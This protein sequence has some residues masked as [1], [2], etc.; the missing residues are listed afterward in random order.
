MVKPSWTFYY[1]LAVKYFDY[2]GDLNMDSNFKTIDGINYN[3]E[4]ID[5]GVWVT[6]Q[7]KLCQKGSIYKRRLE[8]LKKLNV[9][10]EVDLMDEKYLE[11]AQNYF[12]HYHNLNLPRAFKTKNGYDYDEDGVDLSEWLTSQIKASK[13]G[14]LNPTLK[15]ALKAIGMSFDFNELKWNKQYELAKTYYEFHHNLEVDRAFKTKNGI[16]FD[17]NGISLGRWI[18]TQRF[19]YQRNLL[20]EDKIKKLQAIGMIFSLAQNHYEKMTKLAETYFAHYGNLKMKVAFKTKNGY[21]Y[22]E[23]GIGLGEWVNTQKI[24]CRKDLLKDDEKQILAQHDLLETFID[25]SEKNMLNVAKLYFAAHGNLSVPHSFKTLNGV[26]E[27]D[28]GLEL[29][30]WVYNQKRYYAK[31]LLSSDE[32]LQLESL[33][34][35]WNTKK[36]DVNIIS[37]C[38]NYNINYE[39]NRETLL[40][41]SYSEFV[42]KLLYLQATGNAIIKP[43]GSLNDIFMMSSDCLKEKIGYTTAELISF[44]TKYIERFKKLLRTESD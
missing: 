41:L 26:D 2:Y 1:N 18:C 31:G 42:S 24:R 40:R 37:V 30:K 25:L 20:S 15:E 19:N 5:L 39:L 21:D 34:I 23:H 11:L 12:A 6:A 4:G 3:E 8:L 43:D 16:D 9:G 27:N 10:H 13:K 22:D 35:I 14:A 28:S 33:G 32:V 44:M 38:E 17:E 29:G 36:V 7:I